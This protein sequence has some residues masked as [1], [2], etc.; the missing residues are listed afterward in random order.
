MEQ[1]IQIQEEFE[2]LISQL[3]KLK[4]VS[5]ITHD[6]I[7][8]AKAVIK[9]VDDFVQSSRTF[10]EKL[11]EDSNTKSKIIE[12]LISN[13]EDSLTKLD[14]K[15]I[16]LSEGIEN[17]FHSFKE[18]MTKLTEANNRLFKE[19]VTSTFTKFEI[20]NSKVATEVNEIAKKNI[21]LETEIKRL[22]NKLSDIQIEH[23]RSS[24]IHRYLLIGGLVLAISLGGIVIIFLQTI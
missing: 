7:A 15:T 14:Q 20:I 24:K 6:N 2:K 5:D 8:S 13:L 1:T 22:Y 4:K 18:L 19:E 9:G 23:Y 21:G 3:E 12:N 17:E 16:R 11:T 10:A